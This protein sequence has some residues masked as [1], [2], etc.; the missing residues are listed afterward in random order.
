MV[1]TINFDKITVTVTTAG[2]AVPIMS[3]TNA[4]RYQKAFK[5]YVPTTNTGVMYVGNSSV[6]NT[7]DPIAKGAKEAFSVDAEQ[8]GEGLEFD[9]SQIYVDS[10]NNG[11]VL[12]VIFQKAI[13]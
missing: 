5:V 12:I 8:W 9:L 2:T 4:H 6:D 13:Y 7:W 10:A 1:A 3:S 11:D